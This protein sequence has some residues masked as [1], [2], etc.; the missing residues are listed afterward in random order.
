MER[1]AD[2][3]ALVHGY[4]C[5]HAAVQHDR[6]ENPPVDG[7]SLVIIKRSFT[8]VVLTQSLQYI[9]DIAGPESQIGEGLEILWPFSIEAETAIVLINSGLEVSNEGKHLTP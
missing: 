6:S 2:H 1:S 4:L 5:V 8:V 7:S 3:P 9:G